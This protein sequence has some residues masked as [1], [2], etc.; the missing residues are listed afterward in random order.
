M[1]STFLEALK[2]FLKICVAFLGIYV[3]FLAKRR[4]S[5]VYPSY[6]NGVYSPKIYEGFDEKTSMK[7]ISFGGKGLMGEYAGILLVERIDFSSLNNTNA[8]HRR[9]HETIMD[10]NIIN[11]TNDSIKK[12]INVGGRYLEHNGKVSRRIANKHKGEIHLICN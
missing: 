5:E 9:N 7:N 2:S 8:I 12:I 6:K 10:K 4:L 11:V 1:I 3:L